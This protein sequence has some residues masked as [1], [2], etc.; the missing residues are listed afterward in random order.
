MDPTI[1]IKHVLVVAAVLASLA[2]SVVPASAEWFAD[3]YAG[4]ASTKKS[5]VSVEGTK[6]DPAGDFTTKHQDVDFDASTSFGG[7]FGYWDETVSW[8]GVAL[9]VSH[10]RP[11]AGRQTAITRETDADGSVRQRLTFARLD[12]SAT[13][14]SFD[15]MFRWPLLKTEEFPK[16]RLQPY[17]S[18]GVGVVVATARDTT[19][20]GPPNNQSTTDSSLGVKAAGGVAWQLYKKLFLF[21]EYRFTSISPEFTFSPSPAAGADT[22]GKTRVGMDLNTHQLLLGVSYRF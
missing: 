11:D 19:N 17:V 21:G 16:G 9:D 20:F 1:R 15:L 3:L 6:L 7:R 4:P 18:A 8:L 12:I 10:F 5:Q 13:L 2:I 14:M 22:T